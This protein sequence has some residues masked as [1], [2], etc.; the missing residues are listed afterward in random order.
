MKPS[1]AL[2]LLLSGMGFALSG[3]GTPGQAYAKQH[4]DLP[5]AHLQ[6]LKTGKI[7]DG[8]AVAGMTREQIQKAMG[9]EPA[10]YTKV[11]G[12]D[13]WVYERKAL[14]STPLEP[15]GGGGGNAMGSGGGQ[16]GGGGRNPSGGDTQ[17][18]TPDL[19]RTT[20][21]FDGEVATRAE[22]IKGGQ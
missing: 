1:I 15:V 16:S 22:T 18:A 17:P 7:P 2:V 3:C 20:I 12:H 6:I 13:A 5:P 10:Q 8:D 19:Y 9:R 21:I 14:V 11:D 4:P